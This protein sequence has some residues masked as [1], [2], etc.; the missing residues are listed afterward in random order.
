MVDRS[1][2]V[3][4][5]PKGFMEGRAVVAA[6]LSQLAEVFGQ[7]S[8]PRKPRGVRHPFGGIVSLVFLGL[9]A[10]ITEMAV[11]ERWATACWPELKDALGFTRNKPPCDTTISRAL[12]G[13]RLEEFR[14]A[15]IHWL[16]RALTDQEGRWVAAVDGKTCC[17]G[18][19]ADGSPVQMLNVFLQKVKVTLDQWSVGGDKTN[20]PGSLKRHLSEL[21]TAYPALQLLTG[22]AIYAQRPLLELLQQHGCDYLFQVKHNQPDML[23]ALRTCFAAAASARPQHEVIEKRGDMSRPAGCGST[24]P[25]PRISASV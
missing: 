13:L 18:R 16:Q 8:D 4:E 24:C 6:S 7:I 9:L 10:R 21:L 3:V 25:T 19:D 14:Q 23:E 1:G 11:V 5:V 2:T 20:E 12:A 17:Q 22:D 15:F